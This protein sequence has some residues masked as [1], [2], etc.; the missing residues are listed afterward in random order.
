MGVAGLWQFLKRKCPTSF[1]SIEEQDLCGRR[2]ALDAAMLFT[3]CL[4]VTVRDCP[5][6]EWL[7]DFANMVLCRLRNLSTSGAEIVIVMDG[8]PPEQKKHAHAKRQKTHN[9]SLERLNVAR[10]TQVEDDILKALR[11]TTRMTRKYNE[12]ICDILEGVG[13]T[14]VTADAEAEQYAAEMC[15]NAEVDGVISEDGD[16][17]ASGAAR[18]YRGF[19]NASQEPQMVELIT[20]LKVL[21]LTP[22]QFQ[23]MCVLSGTDFHP[24]A[25][26]IGCVKGAAIARRCNSDEQLINMLQLNE[27]TNKG[28]HAAISNFGMWVVD[29]LKN[30]LPRPGVQ[31]LNWGENN[32]IIDK[33]IASFCCQNVTE[34]DGAPAEI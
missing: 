32:N 10:E 16:T 8:T 5:E 34:Y 29:D 21:D 19:C 31:T 13:F 4:K 18:L 28:L 25:P 1:R 12:F 6:S 14:I 23:W 15:I 2:L 33:H 7:P 17:L 20:I 22:R 11:A 9:H 26:R 27:E 3:T 30:P 24:G